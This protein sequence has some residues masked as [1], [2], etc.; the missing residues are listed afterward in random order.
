MRK[1]WKI[2]TF[3]SLSVIFL[4]Q[5]T[6]YIISRTMHL[7][8]SIKVINPFFS[9]TYI[10]NPNAAFGI[11]IGPPVLM[12]ILTSVATILLIVYFFRLREKGLLIYLGLAM[13]I[14]GAIGNLI[15]RI[16]M[17]QVID[18]IEIGVRKFK[19]PVFNIADSFVTIG[20]IA[21]LWVWIFVKNKKENE[22]SLLTN[23]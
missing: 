8:Q 1:K 5:L 23:P 9:I 21:I 3:T 6:K 13:I 19:W 4:D 10:K 15:D 11:S 20:I 22:D 18:F 2:L 17:K 16:R 7:G 14:G 12:M